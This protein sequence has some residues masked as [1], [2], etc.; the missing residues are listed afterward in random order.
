MNVQALCEWL[1]VTFGEQPWVAS[2]PACFPDMTG[3]DVCVVIGCYA[4]R[5]QWYELYANLVDS[6]TGKH[7][8]KFPHFVMMM[9]H[10]LDSPLGPPRKNH[11]PEAMR[12]EGSK[13]GLAGGSTPDGNPKPQKKPRTQKS[14]PVAAAADN[15]PTRT[16][17]KVR[18]VI[19]V[20]DLWTGPLEQPSVRK[21]ADHV[22]VS[23]EVCTNGYGASYI[24]KEWKTWK[25]VCGK[26]NAAQLARARLD[27]RPWEDAIDLLSNPPE[28][29][30]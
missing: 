27:Q 3:A 7:L 21:L 5:S 4:E 16:P 17:W 14:S 19:A 26:L 23:K 6:Q 29:P 30:S 2:F 8:L 18:D 22:L 12:R 25:R 15:A 10:L 13:R 1:R 20:W 11:S 24:R 9:V 28:V